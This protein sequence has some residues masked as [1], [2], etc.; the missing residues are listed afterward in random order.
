MVALIQN[1]THA[2]NKGKTAGRYQF[3]NHLTGTGLKS[4]SI[5]LR[6]S[7]NPETHSASRLADIVMIG[8]KL[9]ISHQR[10]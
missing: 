4:R 5:F 3:D 8:Q 1:E 2:A 10:E 9:L 6:I 7:K